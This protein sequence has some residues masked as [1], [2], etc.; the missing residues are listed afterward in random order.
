MPRPQ[1]PE[2]VPHT[3]LT[4]EQVSSA[5]K[6]RPALYRGDTFA[7]TFQVLDEDGGAFDLTGWTP[8]AQARRERYQDSAGDPLIDFACT[9]DDAAT[10]EMTYS[11]VPAQSD[12]IGDNAL[13]YDVEIENDSTGV[14]YTIR[15]GKLALY[16]HVSESASLADDEDDDEE[17]PGGSPHLWAIENLYSTGSSLPAEAEF[18]LLRDYTQDQSGKRANIYSIAAGL[19]MRGDLA[20][21]SIRLGRRPAL[22]D[23]LREFDYQPIRLVGRRTA[24]A[25]VGDA[26]SGSL[27]DV[28][29]A[30]ATDTFT[31]A[32]FDFLGAG[33]RAGMEVQ[34]TENGAPTWDPA[35][36][37]A[38][39]IVSIAESTPASGLFNVITADTALV[40][41]AAGNDVTLQQLAPY[42]PTKLVDNHGLSIH[43]WPYMLRTAVDYFGL[44]HNRHKNLRGD[45]A[46]EDS[47]V[48]GFEYGVPVYAGDF[49]RGRKLVWRLSGMAENVGYG[50]AFVDYCIDIDP[51][52]SSGA[53]ATTNRVRMASPQFGVVWTGE[54]PWR[55]MIEVV[56]LGAD[57]YVVHGEWKLYDPSGVLLLAWES[58]QVVTSGVDWLAPQ[59]DPHRVQVRWRVE[60]DKAT[61]LDTF[62]GTYQGSRQGTNLLRW[63]EDAFEFEYVGFPRRRA[64]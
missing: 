40:D 18:G 22:L 37:A 28:T 64:D 23:S 54:T 24:G 43:G 48:I 46:G 52:V 47:G 56:A 9:V 21:N 53:F 41:A 8:R 59:A 3:A 1:R 45:N 32:A 13:V 14:T 7:E 34:W 20:G 61:R 5:P 30:A 17:D 51:A 16:G 50:D 63:H 60:R 15:Y 42:Y 31:S 25:T 29:V 10:G 36:I 4:P 12:T 58:T 2:N 26:D 55:G 11:S 49:M 33:F 38:F 44:V 27:T 6:I 39:T 35:N 62:D 19:G 57:S